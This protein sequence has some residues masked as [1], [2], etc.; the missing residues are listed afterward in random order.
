[1]LG[2]APGLP[3]LTTVGDADHVS[4]LEAALPASLTSLML[5]EEF[6]DQVSAVFGA[7][8]QRD[9]PRVADPQ[10]SRA[11]AERSVGL[12]RV[13]AAFVAE[14]ADFFAA[15]RCEWTWSKLRLLSLTSRLL[16][17]D[18]GPGTGPSASDMLCRAARVIK[19][20]PKL[21]ILEIW[22]GGTRLA[23]LFRFEVAGDKATVT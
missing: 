22:N 19:Q 21:Q 5:F 2:P 16:V 12:E 10:V 20:M 17:P 14:A 3:P 6:S 4:T 15:V 8:P 23:R 9:A 13:A 7:Q 18:P 1:M 11:L